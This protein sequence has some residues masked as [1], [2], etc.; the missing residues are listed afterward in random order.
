[1]EKNSNGRPGPQGCRT[2]GRASRS[3]KLREMETHKNKK[4]L[5]HYAGFYTATLL[6]SKIII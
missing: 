1:M 4:S 2:S 5:Y 3:K 6:S